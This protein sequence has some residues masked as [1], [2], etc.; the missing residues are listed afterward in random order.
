M[1]AAALFLWSFL[2]CAYALY[3]FFLLYG[4]CKHVTPSWLLSPSNSE[5]FFVCSLASPLHLHM[6]FL[7][8]LSWACCSLGPISSYVFTLSTQPLLLASAFT[9]LEPPKFPDSGLFFFLSQPQPNTL[10]LSSF[11]SYIC[12]A[13]ETPITHSLI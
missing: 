6:L 5:L 10:S 9:F 1:S 2:S 3:F 4:A 13:S 11:H 12:I 8:L 7:L